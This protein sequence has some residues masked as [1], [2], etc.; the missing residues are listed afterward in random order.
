[1]RDHEHRFGVLAL[2]LNKALEAR[3]EA[4]PD[5]RGFPRLG[6]ID[7][8]IAELGRQHGGDR[9]ADGGDLR[10]EHPL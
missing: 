5:L 8:H 4:C 6:G 7:P 1:V 9:A 2:V 10:R 3:L